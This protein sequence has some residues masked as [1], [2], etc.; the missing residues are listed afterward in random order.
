[1]V[2]VLRS[3]TGLTNSVSATPSLR[4]SMT[5]YPPLPPVVLPRCESANFHPAAVSAPFTTVQP[6][7]AVLPSNASLGPA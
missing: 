4:E 1:M 6:A 2:A 5:A 3:A 7:G